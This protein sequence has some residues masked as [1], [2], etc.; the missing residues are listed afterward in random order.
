MSR[1]RLV[2]LLLAL[3]TLVAYLPATRNGFLYYD[4]DEYITANYAVQAGLTLPGARWAFTSTQVSNWHPITWLSHMADCTLFGLNAGAHHF[5]NVL[6]HAANTALLFVLLW[7]LTRKI[8][9]SAVVA[10]LFAWHPLHVESVA[11]L[12]ERKDVLSTFFALLALL[13]YTKFVKENCRRSFWLAV[14]FFTLGLM[15]KPMLV[16]L[17]CVL[18]LL[19]FWPLNRFRIANFELRFFTKLVAEKIPFFLLAAASCVVTLFAQR[20]AMATLEAVP[21]SWR[22]AN[23][24]VSGVGYLLKIFWP[25]DLA[26][27]YPLTHFSTPLVALAATLLLLVSGAAWHWRQARPY[28]L[29]GWCWFLGTLMPVI[30]LVQVGVTAMADRYTYIPAIGIFLVVA[31]GLAEFASPRPVLK[32]YVSVSM[33]VILVLCI[34]L[35]E[36][37]IGFWRT[38]ET[39]FRHAISVTQRNDVAHGNLGY[40]LE[41]QGRHAEALAEYRTEVQLNPGHYQVHFSIGN[42]LLKLGRYGEALTEFQ[43]CLQLNPE[44]PALHNAVGLALAA[45]GETDGALAQFAD[46]QRLDPRYGEPHLGTADILFQQGRDTNAVAE[47]WAAVKAEPYNVHILS[48]VAR[49]LSANENVASRDGESAL[50][51]ALKA[52]DL[53]SGF[54]PEVLDVLG[55]AFAE[56]GDF[57]NAVASAQNALELAEAGKLN[58]IAAIHQRLELYQKQQPWREAPAASVPANE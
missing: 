27:A 21:W 9:P 36:M 7:R 39:L 31:F 45:L 4:D 49:R 58:R 19:D 54:Q 34:G 33:A 53:A 32:R 14:S 57:T 48:A 22:L 20:G 42:M 30:G 50:A 37:Q 24:V 25:V 51:L 12:S 2:A 47:L 46:A 18:L 38:S 40:A 28:F 16:T 26:V 35:T 1:P 13:S 11:W 10:A 5:V 23:A 56:A 8:W 15:A 29:V 55:M 52:N 43:Q 17:P 3:V 41:H 44:V 6:F